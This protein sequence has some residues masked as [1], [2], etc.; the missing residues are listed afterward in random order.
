[1]PHAQLEN[2]S[3]KSRPLLVLLDDGSF[4][5]LEHDARVRLVHRALVSGD[6]VAADRY[7]LEHAGWVEKDR[8]KS[9]APEVRG[10][11]CEYVVL[12]NGK[13]VEKG[14]ILQ[15]LQ[16]EQRRGQPPQRLGARLE[17]P[18]A[19]AP[20]AVEVGE[21]EEREDGGEELGDVEGA[22]SHRARLR[23]LVMMMCAGLCVLVCSR[24]RRGLCAY[25]RTPT[26][27]AEARQMWKRGQ[28]STSV[29]I[30]GVCAGINSVVD[31]IWVC[32]GLMFVLDLCISHLQ[33]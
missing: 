2:T 28:R 1:M 21:G 20:E 7:A 13:E 24:R 15:R 29:G 32:C 3:R 4:D 5:S 19:G 11:F 26:R 6:A 9:P 16:V 12:I 18:A 30:A 14:H 33:Q 25:A 31:W 10:E 17:Q 27:A 23:G 22:A 8:A